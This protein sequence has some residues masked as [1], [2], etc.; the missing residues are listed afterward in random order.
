MKKSTYALIAI[1]AL[2]F[3]LLTIFLLIFREPSR[4]SHSD[5]TPIVQEPE[6]ITGSQTA[7]SVAAFTAIKIECDNLDY[8]R[9]LRVKLGTDTHSVSMAQGWDKYVQYSVSDSTLL[10]SIA[11]NNF[12]DFRNCSPIIIS[13]PAIKS[14]NN[15]SNFQLTLCGTAGALSIKS[16]PDLWLEGATI[17]SISLDATDD[18]GDAKVTFDIYL[19]AST[20][21]TFQLATAR[22]LNV[23]FQGDGINRID[24]I[25]F[26]PSAASA[27]YIHDV[28]L[29]AGFHGTFA[30]TG[31]QKNVR[32]QTSSPV[33][34][35]ID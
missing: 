30:T 16:Y 9:L 21:G 19:T 33:T 11:D 5:Y 17:S 8:S 35:N 26:E 3:L 20:L 2:P 4:Y 6:T 12:I 23:N 7:R 13:A 10:I 27:D 15:D 25:T 29:P 14:I 22:N 34:L 28:T 1:V 32:V 31:T 24:N 18:E